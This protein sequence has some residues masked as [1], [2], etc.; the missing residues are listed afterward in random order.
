MQVSFPAVLFLALC[1]RYAVA[2]PHTRSADAHS[3]GIHYTYGQC[4]L[5]FV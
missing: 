1:P 2:R 5:F 3:H 4:V